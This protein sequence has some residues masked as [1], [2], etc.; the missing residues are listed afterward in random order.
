I[1]LESKTTRFDDEL[2]DLGGQQGATLSCGRAPPIRDQRANSRL[3]LE[4]PVAYELGDDFLRRVGIDLECLAQLT[5]RRE[6]GAWQKLA[7]HDRLRGGVDDLSV[8]WL[9]RPERHRERKH[10]VLCELVQLHVKQRVTRGNV[11]GTRRWAAKGLG[12]RR[13]GLEPTRKKVAT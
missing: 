10:C 11:G 2:L 9:A 13:Q 3:D 8:G 7:G 4:Q 5:H 6:R 12:I 1:S